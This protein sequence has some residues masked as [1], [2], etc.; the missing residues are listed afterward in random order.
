MQLYNLTCITLN[1]VVPYLVYIGTN[2]S[3]SCGNHY[4]GTKKSYLYRSGSQESQPVQYSPLDML[5]A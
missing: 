2:R 4:I 1:V 5:G 3:N